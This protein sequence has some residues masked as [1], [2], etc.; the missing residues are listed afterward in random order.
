MKSTTTEQEEIREI[1]DDVL[2]VHGWAPG[3]KAEGT[4]RFIY[5]NCDGLANN[6]GG[7]GKLDKAKETIDDLEADVVAYNEHKINFSHKLNRNGMSQ[8]FN[9]GECEVRSV[10]G[11]N[12]HEKEGGRTQE[13]GTS[14][15]LFG[16]LIQQHDFEASGKDETGLGR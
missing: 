2:E 1:E 15:L 8:M 7:N 4:T 10:A 3:R 9:G 5:E 14:M 12:V 16:P 11:H 6:I 13:G